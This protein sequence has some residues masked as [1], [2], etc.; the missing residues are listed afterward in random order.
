ML[1][2]SYNFLGETLKRKMPWLYCIR[3]ILV[4]TGYNNV[5]ENNNFVN[6]KW[7][8]L[9]VR[10]KLKDLFLNNWYTLIENASNS[11][12]Y[13]LFKRSFGFE[14]YLS[15]TPKNLLNYITRFRTRNH[16]LPIEIGN[17]NRTPV[18][19][20]Y[21][22]TC[23]NKLGDEFHYLFE[24]SLFNSLRKKYIKNY[25]YIRPS[26]F[27]LDKLMTTNDP[28]DLKKCVYL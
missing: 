10:Q 19:E 26:T 4:K 9:A 3:T 25:F 6:S 24:C 11:T 8:K 16:R 2:L 22:T 13:K 5:W 15:K 28:K 27:K 18:N 7:L 17:W 20:R 1:Q 14:S 21:C 12:F 23:V